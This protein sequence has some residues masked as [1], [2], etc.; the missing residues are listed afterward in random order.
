MGS[1]FLASLPSRKKR[2]QTA[3]KF[4]KFKSNSTNASHNGTSCNTTEHVTEDNV[5]VP[6]PIDSD[7]EINNDDGDDNDDDGDQKQFSITEITI[8]QTTLQDVGVAPATAITPDAVTSSKGSVS[9]P[10][11]HQTPSPTKIDSYF[12]TTGG[13]GNAKEE[14]DVL[15]VQVGNDDEEK[16][17]RI[18]SNMTYHVEKGKPTIAS[19][20][21]K[22][23]QSLSPKYGKCNWN[24]PTITNTVAIS[25]RNTKDLEHGQVRQD[26]C[27]TKGVNV[28]STGV[29]RNRND[30]TVSSSRATTT[31]EW[32]EKNLETIRSKDGNSKVN[33]FTYDTVTTDKKSNHRSTT[34]STSMGT[35]PST[36]STNDPA[37]NIP[38][39][40]ITSNDPAPLERKATDESAIDDN[41]PKISSLALQIQGLIE[42]H[43]LQHLDTVHNDTCTQLN[44]LKQENS[45]LKQEVTNKHK[46]CQ[47]LQTQLNETNVENQNLMVQIQNL[48]RYKQLQSIL[49]SKN[50]E[51]ENLLGQIQHLEM[52]NSEFQTLLCK[53]KD[54]V[55]QLRQELRQHLDSRNEDF[56]S[57]LA[58]AGLELA[59]DGSIRFMQ[60][61]IPPKMSI[62]HN[63][64]DETQ[65]KVGSEDVL[66]LDGGDDNQDSDNNND[67]TLSGQ[68]RPRSK[69]DSQPK[70]KDCKTPRKS[71]KEAKAPKQKD[72]SQSIKFRIL[73]FDDSTS[74]SSHE[75]DDESESA[76]PLSQAIDLWT[77]Q[78]M[79]GQSQKGKNPIVT[80]YERERDS[81]KTS[82][83]NSPEKGTVDSQCTEMSSDTSNKVSSEQSNDSK[84]FTNKKAES[85]KSDKY[86]QKRSPLIDSSGCEE[87]Y[88]MRKRNGSSRLSLT[89]LK[90]TQKENEK[91]KKEQFKD[92]ASNVGSASNS[93]SYKY[94]EVVRKKDERRALPGRVCPECNGF[95]DTVCNNDVFDKNQLVGDISRH[96]CRHT[97]PQTPDNFWD[98]SFIDEKRE[99]MAIGGNESIETSDV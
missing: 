16:S 75:N 25:E 80:I 77:K 87:P 47:K 26:G 8:D 41:Q 69:V 66:S 44:K 98:L 42:T 37:K 96:R 46:T 85:D 71:E 30:C 5:V 38:L 31:S 23:I 94:C 88:S 83:V 7:H 12:S 1:A 49:D 59:E 61:Y 57:C 68:K 93:P 70:E 40:K 84:P 11:N 2:R 67:K 62:P 32:Q 86:Q 36:Q 13:T 89:R 65:V 72:E 53:S 95:F 3:L 76:E 20:A 19:F 55:K 81:T 97:P 35:D 82:F 90:R 27:S 21:R 56:R 99:K 73:S 51:N 74:T 91:S 79:K 52:T 33:H 18:D 29:I 45:L 28:S 17:Q 48:E 6:P 10:N 9:I 64:L 92:E 54:K 50:M 24:S 78:Q 15:S 14:D 39:T 63:L 22:R 58:N 43:T 60:R 34:R 4:K